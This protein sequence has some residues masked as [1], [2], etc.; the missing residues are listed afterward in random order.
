MC[1]LCKEKPEEETGWPYNTFRNLPCIPCGLLG[2]DH[3]EVPLHD[4]HAHYSDETKHW[5][6]A[7]RLTD[8]EQDK[9]ISAWEKS[10]YRG[11]VPRLEQII[12]VVD[13]P[14]LWMR[15]TTSA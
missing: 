8:E 2:D 5:V 3:E 15:Q 14:V 13:V 12:G 9:V 4:P 6:Y 11:R 10:F 7:R 1:G